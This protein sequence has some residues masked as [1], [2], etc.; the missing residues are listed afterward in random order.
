MNVSS[1]AG[2]YVETFPA[3]VVIIIIIIIIFTSGF[4]FY[5]FLDFAGLL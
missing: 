5:L 2:I 4:L 1:F 3:K